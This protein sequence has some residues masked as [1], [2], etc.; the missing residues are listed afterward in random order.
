MWS[1]DQL[2]YENEN[3]SQGG[4]VTREREKK[5]IILKALNENSGIHD[6]GR[7]H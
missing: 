4:Q 1:E 2:F 3:N 7:N 5:P 6:T